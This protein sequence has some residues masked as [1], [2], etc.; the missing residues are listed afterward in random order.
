MT[1]AMKTKMEEFAANFWHDMGFKS[2]NGLKL[3]DSFKAG[4]TAAYELM[5]E[6]ERELEAEKI[7][8][9]ALIDSLRGF[10][11]LASVAD[12]RDKLK[13]QLEKAKEAL[14]FYAHTEKTEG[15]Y[16]V[17]INED[18]GFTA[19]ETLKELGE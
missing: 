10:S 11:R 13:A 8:H 7:G 12:E 9:L 1:P 16:I 5:K 17:R 6:R 19:R 18:M 4:F 14:R 15:T 2:T 3:D